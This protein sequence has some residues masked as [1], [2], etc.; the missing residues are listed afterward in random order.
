MY[1]RQRSKSYS[2]YEGVPAYIFAHRGLSES[3]PEDSLSSWNLAA[4]AGYAV[5]GDFRISS[6]GVPVCMHD[7]TV[8]RTTDGTGSVSTM[9]AA[10]L[11]ALNNGSKFNATG[12]AT[13]RVPTMA[14]MLDLIRPT[15]VW[16]LPEISDQT[17]AAGR[18]ICNVIRDRGMQNRCMVQ[19][20]ELPPYAILKQLDA[21]YPEIA[22]IVLVQTAWAAP[23]PADLTAAG[24]R[25]VGP[26]VGSAYFNAAW[27]ASL[28][29]AGIK[30][31][32]YTVDTTA[33]RAIAIAAAPDRMFSGRPR[34]ATSDL[35]AAGVWTENWTGIS[36]WM[37]GE[38]WSSS[39]ILNVTCPRPYN[40]S[41]GIDDISATSTG[42]VCIARPLP[43][44][45]SYT[46]D[47]SVTLKA[48]NAD[49][50]RWCGIQLLQQDL[51]VTSFSPVN[52]GRNG[53]GAII[54]QNG[55]VEVAKYVSG[56]T[57]STL[58]TQASTGLVVGTPV[59]L[60]LTVSPTQII[61][62]RLDT[63][64]TATATDNTFRGGKLGLIWAN[65]A[66]RVGPIVGS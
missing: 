36:K 53:Y 54:R 6:D 52:A 12:Y 9:T 57:S 64:A 1:R 23:I 32:P 28:K 42:A 58:A 66:S 38:D 2:A 43:T 5:E 46:I 55:T 30:A 17:L 19:M 61:L 39:G 49:P 48:A 56:V 8:D 62:K 41:C 37:W 27:V 33:Q 15:S 4:Q 45:G 14:Q 18:I 26:D 24:I 65:M 51:L 20:F 29:A 16:A 63:N 22:K 35:Y 7:A 10:Q 50:T 34:L 3:A 21:E 40:G 11:A 59:P 47:M 31:A 44:S 25:F 60:R 13:E